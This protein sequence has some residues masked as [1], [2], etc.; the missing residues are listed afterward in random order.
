MP[1]T[2]IDILKEELHIHRTFLSSDEEAALSRPVDQV[3]RDDLAFERVQRRRRIFYGRLRDRF[4][5]EGKP[6]ETWRGYVA[7]E[8]AGAGGQTVASQMAA[9]VLEWAVRTSDRAAML[10]GF[11]AKTLRWL[12]IL[13]LLL[14]AYTFFAGSRGAGLAIVAVSL[15]LWVMSRIAGNAVAR[16][17]A[18]RTRQ[19]LG[20]PSGDLTAQETVEKST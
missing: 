4:I 15:V 11:V 18:E 20:G 17:T 5:R 2:L 13:L 7:E 16:R 8:E 14:G 12:G 10:G 6:V 9:Q 3:E 1:S 19:L